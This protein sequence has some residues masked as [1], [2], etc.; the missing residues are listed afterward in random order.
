MPLKIARVNHSDCGKEVKMNPLMRWLMLL[1]E[2]NRRQPGQGPVS[3]K[4]MRSLAIQWTSP[5]K[6]PRRP[7]GHGLINEK[8]KPV[9]EEFSKEELHEFRKFV[10]EKL[11]HREQR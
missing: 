3:E 7:H 4:R 6:G 1:Q 11:R 9:W 5:P 8:G 2:L 10:Y